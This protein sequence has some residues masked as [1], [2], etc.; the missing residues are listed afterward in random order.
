MTI[1]SL[2]SLTL[3]ITTFQIISRLN[4]CDLLTAE[5]FISQLNYSLRD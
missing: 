2:K 4:G 5:N 3:I 1:K